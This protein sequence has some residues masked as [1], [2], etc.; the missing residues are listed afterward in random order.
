MAARGKKRSARSRGKGRS[1]GRALL[2]LVLLV[3][4][5]WGAFWQREALWTGLQARLYGGGD[6]PAGL[7]IRGAGDLPRAGKRFAR[8]V[9]VLGIPDYQSRVRLPSGHGVLTCFRMT[10]CDNRL[11]V[12]TDKGLRAPEAV[13]DVIEKRSFTGFM[14]PL[15]RSRFREPLTRGLQREHGLR[16]AAGAHLVLA[17]GIPGPSVPDMLFPAACL[18]LCAFFL[19][20]FVR[21]LT[22]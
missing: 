17:G 2:W 8:P 19:L 21:S 10:G 4:A 7:V 15:E 11:Y 3:V 22:A 20:K 6:A 9:K 5:G 1:A 13:R 12:C 14:G 16:P 18:L